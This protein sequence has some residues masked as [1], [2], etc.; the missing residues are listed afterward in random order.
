[1]DTNSESEQI[2]AFY[3]SLDVE[4]RKEFLE[5]LKRISALEDDELKRLEIIINESLEEAKGIHE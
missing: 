1:M 3:K 5:D 2:L 4:K